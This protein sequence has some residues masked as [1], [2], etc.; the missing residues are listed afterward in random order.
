MSNNDSF[1]SGQPGQFFPVNDGAVTPSSSDESSVPPQAP[2]ATSQP[3]AWSPDPPWPPVVPEPPAWSPIPEPPAWSPEPPAWS[4]EPPTTPTHAWPSAFSVDDDS[5]ADIE[6]P[7]VP[8]RAT[9]PPAPDAYPPRWVPAPEAPTPGQPSDAV[10]LLPPTINGTPA[11]STPETPPPTTETSPLETETSPL[12]TE[13][14]VPTTVE[15]PVI[16][17]S[18]YSTWTALQADEE[19]DAEASDW[20]PIA[21][22]TSVIAPPTLEFP[23]R[24]SKYPARAII[25]DSSPEKTKG[26]R[27]MLIILLVVAILIFLT[28]L[29]M[30]LVPRLLDSGQTGGAKSPTQA[31]Q[32]YL[33]AVARGDATTALAYSATQPSQDTPFTSDD[34]LKASMEANPITDIVVPEGQPTSSP[35]QIQATYTLGGDEVRAHFT[36]QK[37]GRYWLLDGGFLPLNL[38]ELT[39]KGVPLAVNGVGLESATKIFLFPGIYTFTSLNPMLALTAPTFTMAYPESDLVFSEGFTLSQEGTTRIQQAAAGQLD[40]CLS[41]KELQPEGCGFGF[42][43][44]N[45]GEV[46]PDTIAWALTEDSADISTIEPHLDGSSL[47]VAMADTNIQVSFSAVSTDKRHLYDDT[48]GFAEVRADFSDPDHIVVTFGTL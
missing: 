9:E 40:F 48:S 37:H 21:D 34:F 6:S 7:L 39:D 30:F 27:T 13:T 45:V 23:V 46:D 20:S 1:P 17:E 10:P 33:E 8:P 14:P 29:G 42:M 47:T 35:T 2:P 44:T 25:E 43:G 26:K 16:A 18:D 28:A 15:T 19:S 24:S 12:E 31:V 41:S 11:P 5:P 4:P 22:D 32:E 38:S 3:S 36:V